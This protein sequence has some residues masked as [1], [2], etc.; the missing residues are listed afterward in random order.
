M[1]PYLA[2]KS[3]GGGLYRNAHTPLSHGFENILHAYSH[4]YS[5]M[6]VRLDF[7]IPV[8]ASDYQ[9]QI[10]AHR[11]IQT[12]RPCWNEMRWPILN[13]GPMRDW[14]ARTIILLFSEMY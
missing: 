7:R 2:V 5:C 3:K 6:T 13:D 11:G 8:H 4:V 1:L 10:V 9:L 14:N 12:S